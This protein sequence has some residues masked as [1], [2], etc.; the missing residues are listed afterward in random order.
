MVKHRDVLC[1]VQHI[2]LLAASVCRPIIHI[3]FEPCLSKVNIN[4]TKQ[5]NSVELSH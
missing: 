5:W 2:F 3:R 4:S 1:G